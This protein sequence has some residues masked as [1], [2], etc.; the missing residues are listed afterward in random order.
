MDKFHKQ[1]I[2]VTHVEHFN[3][4]SRLETC[5]AALVQLLTVIV[6]N[7]WLAVTYRATS[8][9][10]QPMLPSLDML[11]SFSGYRAVRKVISQHNQNL[12]F[13]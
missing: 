5:V 2:L 4:Q 11:W 8:S 12:Y 1:S 6:V 7:T 10:F 3:D 13:D 9:A